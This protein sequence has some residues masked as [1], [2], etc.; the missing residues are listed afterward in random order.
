MSKAAPGD[1]QTQV[2]HVGFIQSSYKRCVFFSLRIRARLHNDTAGTSISPRQVRS[3]VLF[4]LDLSIT[5][6]IG[7]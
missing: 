4:T 7:A 1:N 6:I 5:W 2:G 3:V